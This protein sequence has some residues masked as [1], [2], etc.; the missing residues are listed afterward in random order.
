MSGMESFDDPAITQAK[1][2]S[3]KSPTFIFPGFSPIEIAQITHHLESALKAYSQTSGHSIS[4]F[5]TD[6]K[7]DGCRIGFFIQNGNGLHQIVA[8]KF[9]KE[10]TEEKKPGLYAPFRFLRRLS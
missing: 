8:G 6:L 2:G 7:I 9:A 5:M 1:N 4:P 3:E 10:V